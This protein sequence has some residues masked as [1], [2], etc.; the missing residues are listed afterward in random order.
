M[1]SQEAI[2]SGEGVRVEKCDV[3]KE[4]DDKE[5]WLMILETTR[6]NLAVR[7]ELLK[8][9]GTKEVNEKG[10]TVLKEELIEK[11]CHVNDDGT[12]SIVLADTPHKAIVKAALKDIKIV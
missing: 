6:Q 10:E 1:Y 9:E 2:D 5:L 8:L 11:V 3:H 12:F 4:W 7:A